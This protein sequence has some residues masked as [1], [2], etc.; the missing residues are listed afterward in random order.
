[1]R[2]YVYSASSTVVATIKPKV[3]SVNCKLQLQYLPQMTDASLVSVL[4]TGSVWFA[5]S[6]V[7]STWANTA[8]LNHFKDPI[9]HTLVR[10]FG[11]ASFGI[12]QFQTSEDY[13]SIDEFAVLLNDVFWPAILLWIAN[14]ANSVALKSA[15]VTLT[16]VVKASIPVF[17]VLV[18]TIQGQAFSGMI[19]LSLIP[20]CVGVALASG[21]DMY[22]SYLGLGAALVSALAQ[23][24]MNLSI[25]KVRQKTG[26][27][28]SKAFLGMT[29]LCTAFTLPVTIVFSKL[30]EYGYS[31]FTPSSFDH[32]LAAYSE[33]QS[34][35]YWPIILMAVAS[36][37]YHVEY[38]LNFVFVGFVSSVTFSVCDIARRIA[39]IIT[40][41]I[42]FDKILTADNWIGIGVALSGVLWYSYLESQAKPSA[43]PTGETE[44][45]VIV[46]SVA[47]TPKKKVQRP[48]AEAVTSAKV[49]VAAT[50][51]T[52]KQTPKRLRPECHVQQAKKAPKVSNAERATTPRRSRRVAE[53]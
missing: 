46:P 36:I 27:S 11:S 10:F 38:A 12:A 1:M 5:S 2:T 16:Y 32:L 35:L 42:L 37:A 31:Q 24:F 52:R 45:P 15:G 39:I 33:A 25:K 20:I 22:F 47:P 3:S 4:I 30:P 13:L 44:K 8:F 51:V 21:S 9:L 23:T 28:G 40:G 29:I 50:S 53:P 43:E 48:V 19:Y 49:E 7:L 18:C 17:T 41:A 6:A 14:C 34:G 26:H